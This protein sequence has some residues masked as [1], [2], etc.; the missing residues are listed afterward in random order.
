[1]LGIMSYMT[2]EPIVKNIY[3]PPVEPF[4]DATV[5]EE[6]WTDD[7]VSIF[8]TFYKNGECN[9]LTFQPVGYFLGIPE[10]L[11]YE[12]KQGIPLNFNREEGEHSLFVAVDTSTKD[13][14]R[15]ELRT[16]HLCTRRDS[17][18]NVEITTETR[19]FAAVDR[20]SND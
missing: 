10:Y 16:R 15:V 14:E 7:E 4:Y 6:V 13:F 17:D 12:D 18:G 9:L 8:A 1:M 11:P 3:S 5:L 19:V 2:V 20:N